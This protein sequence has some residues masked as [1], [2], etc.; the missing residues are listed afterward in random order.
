MIWFALSVRPRQ[1]YQV[2]SCLSHKGYEVFVPTYQSRRSW[3]DRIKT[4]ELPLFPGYVFCRFRLEDRAAPVVTTPGVTRIL[5]I[6]SVPQ[7]VN[8]EEIKAIQ[9]I[10]KS[11]L[12]TGPWPYMREGTR[13]YIRGGPLAGIEG[14]VASLKSQTHLVVSVTL[15][16]RSVSVEVDPAWLTVAGAGFSTTDCGP[17]SAEAFGDWKSSPRRMAAAEDRSRP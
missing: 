1:E 4:L 13:V 17:R 15:L 16:C 5:G 9:L 10:V 3:S 12:R 2:E 14:V 11:R 6:G 7:P 8:A